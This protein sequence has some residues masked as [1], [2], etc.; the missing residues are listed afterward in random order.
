VSISR[1]GAGQVNFADGWSVQ[2]EESNRRTLLELCGNALEA[3]VDPDL[4][5]P[6]SQRFLEA[7]RWFGE[8]ARDDRASTSAVKYVTALERMVMTDER[9]DITSTLSE[10][11]AALSASD[12]EDRATWQAK[13]REAYEFRSRLVHGSMS[14]TASAASRGA[15]LGAELAEVTLLRF[16]SAAGA[17]G[18]RQDDIST[19]RLTAW[20]DALT[21]AAPAP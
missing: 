14:P 16:L 6:I 2:L 11:V 18:L 8:G 19:A 17:T 13:A 9:R 12:P 20:F 15:A 3:A 7:A 5:R 10:R 1:R 21:A 4:E